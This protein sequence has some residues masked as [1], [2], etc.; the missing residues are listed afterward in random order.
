MTMANSSHYNLGFKAVRTAYTTIK[1]FEVMRMFK[2]DIL[3][4]LK[5]G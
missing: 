5:Q 1:G 2:K 4:F 3:N